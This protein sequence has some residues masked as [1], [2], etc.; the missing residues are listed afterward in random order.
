MDTDILQGFG[1][2]ESTLALALD[3]KGAFNAVLPGVLIRQL[4]RMGAPGRIVNFVNFL[5]TRTMLYFSPSDDSPS[6]C[7]VGIPPRGRPLSCFI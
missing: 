2:T 3:L 4:I 7:G 5:T 1:Q 6:S